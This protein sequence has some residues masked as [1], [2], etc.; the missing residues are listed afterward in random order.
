[1]QSAFKIRISLAMPHNDVQHLSLYLS[2]TVSIPN[3]SVITCSAFLLKVLNCFSVIQNYLVPSYPY[4]VQRNYHK[5]K[6]A[7]TVYTHHLFKV[8]CFV[9]LIKEIATL[10]SKLVQ[11]YDPYFNKFT[12][13]LSLL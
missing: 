9:K 3:D 13:N 12:H 11:F 7:F 8:P 1:M 5:Y 4:L 2:S 6:I 10:Y